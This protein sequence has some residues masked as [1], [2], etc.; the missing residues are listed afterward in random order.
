[1][2][3]RALQQLDPDIVLIEGP[4][5]AAAVLELAAHPAMAPP[6]AL[7][8]YEPDAP[9]SAVYY[10]FATFS[11]EWQALRWGLNKQ[12]PVR[13]I[14]F[15]GFEDTPRIFLRRLGELHFAV[16]RGLHLP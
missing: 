11:P 6:V 1:M 2:L 9:T 5:D 10:P 16:F 3:V 13:F 15:E 14:D 4:P 12:V 8:V 7:L